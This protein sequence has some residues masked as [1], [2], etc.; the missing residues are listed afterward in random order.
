MPSRH[1]RPRTVVVPYAYP[2]WGGGSYWDAAAYQQPQPNVT[3]VMPQQ[4]PPPQ[5]II[6]NYTDGVRT[7]VTAEETGGG[8]K[9]YEATPGAKPAPAASQAPK[10]TGS[11]VRDDKPNIYLLALRDK[12]VHEAIGYWARDGVLHYVTPGASI[13]QVDLALL[14]REETQRL[15]TERKLEFDLGYRN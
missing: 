13:R 10:P 1:G 3:V 4:P 14:D 11:Y 12:T 2:V 15:N 6:N 9:V 7:T 5:V 8:L